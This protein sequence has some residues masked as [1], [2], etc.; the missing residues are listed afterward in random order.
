MKSLIGNNDEH[1]HP[2]ES[3]GKKVDVVDVFNDDC[4]PDDN[5]S[6]TPKCVWQCGCF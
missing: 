1:R 6:L 5:D 3:V 4:S 2:P